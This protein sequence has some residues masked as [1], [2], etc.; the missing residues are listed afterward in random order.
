MGLHGAAWGCMGLHGAAWD[1][2]GLHG[3]AWEIPGLTPSGSRF[4]QLP[5][6][7]APHLLSTVAGL[8]GMEPKIRV[9]FT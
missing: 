5:H 8:R 2:M 3:T 4:S 9:H 7:H 6:V 1:C